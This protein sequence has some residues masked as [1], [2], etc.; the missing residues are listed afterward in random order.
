MGIEKTRTKLEPKLS[1]LHLTLPFGGVEVFSEASEGA[2]VEA[3]AKLSW[4]ANKVI[5]SAEATG[6]A[7]PPEARE[8]SL[9]LEP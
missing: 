3:E 9:V 6:A 2:T 5:G 7:A 8:A 1:I 4:A